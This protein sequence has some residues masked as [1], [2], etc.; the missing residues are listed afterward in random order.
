MKGLRLSLVFMFLAGCSDV[1]TSHYKTYEEAA[2]DQLFGRGWLPDFIPS[3]STNITTSNN[4]DLNRSEGEFS[5][6]PAATE[7]FISRL[8]PY[9]GQASPS[10]DFEK[11]VNKR[12]TQG[13]TLYEFKENQYIWVFFLNREKGHAYY[14]MWPVY[15][16][17]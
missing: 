15:S 13:Y 2:K 8:R 7:S 11:V 9:S 3:S 16:G 17:S 14:S 6:P 12:K 4:L 1:V 10:S 5:F